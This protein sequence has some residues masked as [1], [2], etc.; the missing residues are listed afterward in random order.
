VAP[1]GAAMKAGLV[2]GDELVALGAFRVN[3][4]DLGP[5]LEELE[6][7][8]TVEAHF[9]RRDELRTTAITVTALPANVAYIRRREG[10]S[11]AE[12]ALRKGWL[13]TD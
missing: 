12:V 8:T 10:A 11:P 1:G 9:F 4:G 5:R 13:G 6:P 2:P 3:S 7:N